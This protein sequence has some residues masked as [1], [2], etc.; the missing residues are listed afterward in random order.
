MSRSQ[1]R[2]SFECFSDI[3]EGQAA[4]RVLSYSTPTL[5]A[6][7]NQAGSH[8]S[9][10]HSTRVASLTLVFY[11]DML[12]WLH[13]DLTGPWSSRPL[14]QPRGSSPDSLVAPWLTP[15]E[16]I[17]S[18]AVQDMLLDDSKTS[19]SILIWRSG[20]DSLSGPSRRGFPQS[21]L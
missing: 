14:S 6:V 19:T 18:K 16:E 17:C 5:C 10:A 4:V 8:L 9:N 12:L 15:Q 13:L 21:G 2:F 20:R 3:L 7:E 1:S 11:S